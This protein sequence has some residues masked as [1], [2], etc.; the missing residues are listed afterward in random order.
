MFWTAVNVW[1]NLNASHIDLNIAHSYFSLARSL[2]LVN[3]CDIKLD[4]M[5]GVTCN[6]LASWAVTDVLETMMND[7]IFCVPVD[8]H[9]IKLMLYGSL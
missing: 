6:G 4:E 9:T 5:L 1:I 2:K 7:K 3:C 8:S